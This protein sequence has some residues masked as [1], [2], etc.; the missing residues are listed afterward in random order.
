M[1]MPANLP[2]QYYEAKRRFERAKT[3]EEKIKYLKEMLAIMPKH[4]GTN[5]LQADLRAKLSKLKMRAEESHS[6]KKKSH[7]FH[8]K[9]EGAGQVV[10]I[11]APNV[12]KSS[13]LDAYTN[14]E[15]EIASYPFTTR[16]SIV[17]MMP[18]ENIQFQ[19]VDIPAISEDF[20]EPYVIDLVRNCN[21]VLLVL[22][23]SSDDV[24]EH[25]EGP[26]NILDKS[27]VTLITNE[28]DNKRADEPGRVF[29]KTIVLGNK[30]DKEGANERI[31]V[32]RELY[33]EDFPIMMI[34]AKER[35]GLESL[36]RKIF[37]ALDII[38]IYP[39][40]PRDN[41]VDR[42]E[43]LILEK[44]SCVIDAAEALHKEFAENLKFVRIWGKGK[45]D[46]QSIGID[47]MLH[48]EDILEFHI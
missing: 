34:S 20:I 28:K 47:D 38:R 9:K 2:P 6:S 48:D 11:G 43:P 26:Q 32:L 27:K 22:D 18:F 40:S 36:K 45:Y 14:V 10:L 21:V 33:G 1:T 7:G 4:K 13:I 46:G 16:M 5:R 44:G 39:K 15:P 35:K 12:G 41:N 19:L 8:I 42:D 25:L 3:Y 24:L 31:A 29:K 17:G 23:M 37:D 30:S